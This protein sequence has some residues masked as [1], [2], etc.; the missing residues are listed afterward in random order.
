[1]QT[2]PTKTD[3][4]LFEWALKARDWYYRRGP[5]DQPVEEEVNL[6]VIRIRR[7]DDERKG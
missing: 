5:K 3:R 6:I 7:L 4:A 2:R 1:M